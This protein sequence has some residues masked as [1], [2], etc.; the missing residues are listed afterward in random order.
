[1][2]TPSSDNY[3]CAI[4]GTPTSEYSSK[5][6]QVYFVQELPATAMDMHCYCGVTFVGHYKKQVPFL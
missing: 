2:L 5:L 1:M 6:V 3:V 4:V